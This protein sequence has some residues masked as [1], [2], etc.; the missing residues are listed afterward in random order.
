MSVSHINCFCPL[1][2]ILSNLS[3]PLRICQTLVIH[4]DPI[5]DTWEP[6][7]FDPSHLSN[8]RKVKEGLNPFAKTSRLAE[9]I[10][11]TLQ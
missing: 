5:L 6:M 4:Y 2:F 9:L 10:T 7:R 3:L 8:H 1:I 11:L